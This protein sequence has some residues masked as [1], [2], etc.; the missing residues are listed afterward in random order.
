MIDEFSPIFTTFF[1]MLNYSL[2]THLVVANNQKE[3]NQTFS[4]VYLPK[5][6]AGIVSVV[7]MSFIFATI[8]VLSGFV[9]SLLY[10]DIDLLTY[11]SLII[12]AIMVQDIVILLLKGIVFGYIISSIPIYYAQKSNQDNRNKIKYIIKTLIGIFMSI[13]ILEAIFYITKGLI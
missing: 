12:N 4:R 7:S 5:L 6:I 1:L 11:K 10:L 2:Y 13:L 3:T 8:M 9:V